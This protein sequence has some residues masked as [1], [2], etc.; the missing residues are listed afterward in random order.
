MKHRLTQSSDQLVIHAL[1]QGGDLVKLDSVQKS[2]QDDRAYAKMM[3]KEVKGKINET[4]AL[5]LPSGK[6]ILVVGLGEKKEWN[7]RRLIRV[8]RKAVGAAKSMN[9]SSVAFFVSDFFCA[10]LS[11]QQ[12]LELIAQNAEMAAYD[13]KTYKEAPKEGWPTIGEVSYVGLTPGERTRGSRSI[14]V[15]RI[16]GEQIN[17]ARELGNIPGGLMT[18]KALSKYAQQEGKKHGFSVT[19][20][21]EA[22]M[23]ALAMGSILGVSKGST[24]EAQFVTMEWKGSAG[25]RRKP[26][27]FIGKGTTF[28]SGGLNLKPGMHMDEMHFDM[29]GAAAVIA[30]LGAC[31]RMKLKEHVI[32]I[33]P[34]VENMPSGQSY[35]P[36]DILHSMSGKTIEISNTDAEGRVVLADALTYAERYS[37]RAV[38][39]LA[40]LTGA[41]VVALGHH[42]SGLF[43]RD[44]AFGKLVSDAGEGSGDYLWPLPMWD[45]YEDDVRGETGDVLNSS[46]NREAGATNGAM[47]LY[48]FA[49][50]FPRWAHIDIASTMTTSRDQFLGKG[51]SGTGVRLLVELAR[52]ASQGKI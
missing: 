8:V 51:A 9:S 7:A 20:F 46:R 36:G 17:L 35:R 50:K 21:G 14:E 34:A 3:R 41:C 16:I 45:E 4:T 15:G 19:V 49:K 33:F 32:G 12:L 6:K 30:T 39:D 26:I 25:T 43:T 47:F 52:R 42:A 13:F 24:E 28:D 23:K 18:P 2:S 40:T 44:E 22:K 1:F 48:Q 31:A 11:T 37:P 5:L 27:V 29:I 38:V 10:P